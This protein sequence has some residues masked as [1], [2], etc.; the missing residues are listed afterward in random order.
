MSTDPPPPS[1]LQPVTPKRL[2][3]V[4]ARCLAKDPDA[5]WQSA[6]DLARE[7]GRVLEYDDTPVRER[8]AGSKLLWLPWLVAAVAGLGAL[9]FVAL[10][11]AAL[12]KPR[13]LTRTS[14]LAPEGVIDAQYIFAVSPD[15]RFIVSDP[16]GLVLLTPG[17]GAGPTRLGDVGLDPVWSPDDRHI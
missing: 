10:W 2:D 11:R 5:R 15:G 8:G 14:I 13:L 1:S 4:I 7:L 9:V 12:S 3:D 16:I 6:G 17:R